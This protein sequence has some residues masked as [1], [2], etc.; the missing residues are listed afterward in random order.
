MEN[1]IDMRGLPAEAKASIINFSEFIKQKYKKSNTK[2]SK[3]K[4][5]L[6][7]VMEK[8]LYKLPEDFTFNRDELYDR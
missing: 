1:I 8:G 5:K 4:K 3:S 6:I 7:A 2:I